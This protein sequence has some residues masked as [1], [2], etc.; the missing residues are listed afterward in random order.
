MQ[1]IGKIK[2]INPVQQ[3]TESYKKR[4]LVVMLFLMILVL[5]F[6]REIL[7]LLLVLLVVVNQHYLDVLI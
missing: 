2:L 6:Q 4:D 1:V 7:F 3:V 5:M